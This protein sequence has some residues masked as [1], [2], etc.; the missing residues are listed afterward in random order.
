MRD[1]YGRRIDYIRVSVTEKCNLRCTYCMPD[2]GVPRLRHDS[3][4][5]IEQFLAVIEAAADVGVTKVRLTGGE[6]LVRRGIID[7]V[8][9]TAALP[10]IKKVAMTTNGILLP[11]IVATLRRAGLTHLNISIDTF[12]PERYSRLTRGGKLE[13]A[14]AG[15]MSARD[16]GFAKVK[17]NSVV[18]NDTD[19]DDQ[20]RIRRFCEA[21]GFVHQRIAEFS[22]SEE[23]R[24]AL[25][26][27]RPLP[28]QECNRIRLLSTGYL[29]PCLH[30]NVEIPVDWS[31]IGASLR[32]AILAKP[33]RGTVCTNR[34]MAEIGG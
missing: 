22:L 32:E 30:S 19:E 16:I 21:N 7:L 4:L 5:R 3:V 1:L 27:E 33:E 28:C 6:P 9:G 11:G 31:D 13:D 15:A 24:D 29:K 23:K 10:G 20:R 25:G 26:L 18:L 14:I 8:R 12:D 2:D 17:I 34:T